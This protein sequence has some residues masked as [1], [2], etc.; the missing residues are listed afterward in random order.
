MMTVTFKLDFNN[1]FC[2]ETCTYNLVIKSKGL[3]IDIELIYTDL[4]YGELRTSLVFIALRSP[5]SDILNKQS[6]I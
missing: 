5:A 6:F 1:D 3:K 4:M 2:G